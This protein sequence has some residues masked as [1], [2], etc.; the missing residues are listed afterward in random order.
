MTTDS[1]RLQQLRKAAEKK[2]STDALRTPWQET[3]SRH[4]TVP[5]SKSVQAADVI[6]GLSGGWAVFYSDQLGVSYDGA[7]GSPSPPQ[8]KTLKL[9]N[10]GLPE[11]NFSPYNHGTNR[12][13]SK[14]PSLLG[15]PIS[16][17]IVGPTLKAEGNG[18]QWAV[19][20]NSATPGVGDE[21]TIDSVDS[22]LSTTGSPVAP[23]VSTMADAYNLS[24]GLASAS[25][26]GGLYMV[27]LLSG[28]SGSAPAANSGLGDGFIGDGG[29]LG[30]TG[31]VP[32]D[33]T[34]K[35]EIFRVDEIKAD[36]V[37]LNPGKRIASYFTIGAQPHARAVMFFEPHL[38]RLAPVSGSGE[39]LGR[40]RSFVVVPPQT[41]PTGEFLPPYD[42]G[43]V[44]WLVGGFDQ[45]NTAPTN[46]G[47]PSDYNE[48]V[49]LPIPKPIAR[50]RGR[51]QRQ[52]TGVVSLTVGRMMIESIGY[53]VTSDD[54]GKII[55]VYRAS[56][57]G[58]APYGNI[59]GSEGNH[60]T[61]DVF[62]G[63]YEV[64]GFTAST[65]TV[66]RL[67][68]VDPD[69]GRIFWGS[70]DSLWIDDTVD[71]G[72]LQ[73]DFTIHDP[74]SSLFTSTYNDP[75]K[76]ESARL[77]NLID[78]SWV[79]R[80]AK[81]P[82][83][84]Y[85]VSSARPERAVWDTR[86]GENPGSLLELGFR[87]VLFPAKEGTGSFVGTMVPDYDNPIDSRELVLDPTVD[88]A[89][90][91]DIDYS[92][93]VVRCS[94]TPI[95]GVGCDLAPNGIVTSDN[96]RGE[97]ALFAACVPYSMEQGQLGPGF[98]ATSLI[99]EQVPSCVAGYGSVQAD[100]YGSRTYAPLAATVDGVAQT[101]QSGEGLSIYFDDIYTDFPLSG[102]V[103]LRVD[104][105]SGSPALTGAGGEPLGL[106]GYTLRTQHFDAVAGKN[107]TEL[108]GCFGG[109]SYGV[110]TVAASGLVAVLRRDIRGPASVDGIAGTSY[111][112][113]TT[114]GFAKRS[115]VVRFEDASLT[116]GVDGSLTVSLEG[117]EASR[118]LFEDLFSSWVISGGVVTAGAAGEA[119]VAST[120]VIIRG[121]RFSLPAGTVTGL[122]AGSTHYIYVDSTVSQCPVYAEDSSI[123]LP[124]GEHDVL[125]ARVD[126]DGTSTVTNVVDL[127]Y[128][129]QDID[130]RDPILVGEVV[131]GAPTPHFS[132]LADAIDYASELQDPASGDHGQYRE[133][134]IVGRTQ[135]TRQSV[136]GA[137][138]LVI[139]SA[140]RRQDAIGGPSTDMTVS[141]AFQDTLIDLNGHGDLV[142]EG[143]T[144]D[145]TGPS[146]VVP[147]QVP[148]TDS[149]ATNNRLRIQDCKV[150]GTNVHGLYYSPSVT[151][152]GAWIVGN[153]V[154]ST[155]IGIFIVGLEDSRVEG[156]VFTAT[157]PQNLNDAAIRYNS[158]DRNIIRGNIITGYLVGVDND[159]NDNRIQDNWIE[160]TYTNGIR[161]RSGDRVEIR[162]NRLVGIHTDP[163]PM[164]GVL[165]EGGDSVAFLYNNVDLVG[166]PVSSDRGLQATGIT[167]NIKLEGNTF[168]AAI[169]VIDGGYIARNVADYSITCGDGC[170]VEGNVASSGSSSLVVGD[171][172][173]VIGNYIVVIGG[174][175]DNTFIGNRCSILTAGVDSTLS[176]NEAGTSVNVGSGSR[177]ADN[178]IGAV[179]TASGESEIT[180]N[181]A[182]SIVSATASENDAIISDNLLTRSTPGDAINWQGVRVTIE[183]NRTVSATADF[184]LSGN[185]L[186]VEGNRL[187]DLIISGSEC[188][189][190]DNHLNG[191]LGCVGVSC[192]ISGNVIKGI[193]T[194]VGSGSIVIGAS[195][196]SIEHNV[197]DAVGGDI[198]LGNGTSLTGLA[199]TGNK[200]LGDILTTGSATVSDST[201]TGNVV[202]GAVNLAVVASGYD[203]NT[204]T[205]NMVET[206]VDI[207]GDGNVVDGNKIKTTLTVTG[208]GN[209]VSDNEPTTITVEGDSNVIDGNRGNAFVV[210]G[211]RNTVN[212]NEA[213]TSVTLT[214]QT[215]IITNNMVEGGSG[216][217]VATATPV[218]DAGLA[219]VRGN[220]APTLDMSQTNGLNVIE[221]NYLFNLTLGG[222]AAPAGGDGNLITGNIIMNDLTVSGTDTEITG[223]RMG[224]LTASGSVCTVTGN[225]FTGDVRLGGSSVSDITFTG[226][227]LENSGTPLTL[228]G[229]SSEIIVSGNDLTHSLGAS[230]VLGADLVGVVINSNKTRPSQALGSGPAIDGSALTDSSEDIVIDANIIG[231]VNMGDANRVTITNNKIE[232]DKL[233]D[234]GTSKKIGITG[235][236][237]DWIVQ[238]N[239]CLY[240]TGGES[241]IVL[242]GEGQL[243]TGNL[244]ENIGRDSDGLGA[245]PTTYI[246]HANRVTGGN[247]YGSTV[248]ATTN[249]TD[250][251][252]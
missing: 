84:D 55:R 92:S 69:T 165:I 114:Y 133:I 194:V 222:G 162:S 145:F 202:G 18:W 37:V 99:R 66:R 25:F 188:V 198:D 111:E 191:G 64:V 247:V 169:E 40:E 196:N 210:T 33:D 146:L 177:V 144:F 161:H 44:T 61:E 6:S 149:T 138:G 152:V 134:L 19:T 154:D 139:R 104:N 218:S 246:A 166:S 116:P 249:A 127:R 150:R 216:I 159:G 237:D 103:D 115:S 197:I 225:R 57:S 208:A 56:R 97:I 105:P 107:I 27:F 119:N 250:N 143:I 173:Q 181:S 140:S 53:T 184:T 91:L 83:L 45:D 79:E 70:T 244:C 252:V 236:G 8:L 76:I 35:Y 245:A 4:T 50:R 102:W 17:S 89:Q 248:S 142:F 232:G 30:K 88:E 28:A 175:D 72:D 203:D 172:C 219:M 39:Q 38:T 148:F 201:L 65:Y 14:G 67:P 235:T 126:T 13:G 78:P 20:D 207:S 80:S 117:Q 101:I 212:A 60:T 240:R 23:I 230:I 81:L 46:V 109:G 176:G 226:N 120:T 12:F 215:S 41:A 98:R 238:G 112:Y 95:P 59:G 186:I 213:A 24:T 86:S 5:G 158:G 124:D 29:G 163:A 1:E 189:V 205:G 209:V 220:W 128:V 21:L 121:E 141:W 178:E 108:R 217:T 110:A 106:F 75:D 32:V 10:A 174:G 31:I 94:H 16:I 82:S 157:T 251:T 243:V 234:G 62:L 224:D 2:A 54:V 130:H 242:T 187:N 100:I 168:D 193:Q 85:G 68:E 118:A 221:G 160:G 93:G 87:M 26:P 22:A 125:L 179:L 241:S 47:A 7:Q 71:S 63:W 192:R 113:D 204:F 15:H 206:S 200:L 164:I 153:D 227:I 123:P 129:M 214:G 9:G 43:P 199:I 195:S 231:E 147:T 51:T 137:D 211:D 223:N 52:S 190:S 185:T 155:D 42:G 132:N 136:I 180:G 183:G 34:A 96:P 151:S 3:M 77:Q 170:Y 74:V 182:A 239:R 58:T 233:S 135:E 167:S 49:A 131:D 90:Y 228:V 171:N 36:G 122:G 156:N 11:I 73:L 229:G 48:H